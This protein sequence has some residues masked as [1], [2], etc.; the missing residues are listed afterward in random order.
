MMEGGVRSVSCEVIMG[1][2]SEFIG[3]LLRFVGVANTGFLATD[4]I[5]GDRC[6][7]SKKETS[8]GV[9]HHGD[10]E[11]WQ[12]DD[13]D[14]KKVTGDGAAGLVGVPGDGEEADGGGEVPEAERGG[15]E[16]VGQSGEVKPVGPE[17][18]RDHE[19]RVDEGLDGG[20]PSGPGG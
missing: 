18:D 12:I 6:G 11:Q 7:R 13:G 1:V 16:G 17:A 3:W 19:K 9:E 5:R 14:F 8:T 10:E 4:S 15:D 20:G 2:G